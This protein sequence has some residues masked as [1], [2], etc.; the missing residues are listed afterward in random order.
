MTTVSL[1]E[2]PTIVSSAT[3]N[4][5]STS[6]PKTKPKTAKPPLYKVTRGKSEQYLKDEAAL[7]DY[8]IDNG[9]NETLLEL[10]SGEERAGEDLRAI[11]ADARAASSVIDADS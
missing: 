11:I 5:L 7:Q 6:T 8:L 4:R 2:N 1:S 3:I 10:D 9:L